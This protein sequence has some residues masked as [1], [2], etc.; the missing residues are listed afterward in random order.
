MKK[1]FVIIIT[2]FSLLYA[3]NQGVGIGTLSPDASARLD[4]VATDKGILIP[5]VN[6]VATNNP[7]PVA[8]PAV[9]LL[10]YNQATINDVVPGF[11]YWDGIKW[12]NL[13]AGVS[14]DA[15]LLNGNAGTNSA[16]NF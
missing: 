8:S 6:L 1:R 13:S 3:Q 16:T 10:V 4:V 5:R 7:A 9:S 12:V 2:C 11:Y 15:W 14:N